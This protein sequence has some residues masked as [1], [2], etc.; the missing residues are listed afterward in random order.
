MTGGM[1][2]RVDRKTQQ[3]QPEL[4]TSWKVS[5][6]GRTIRFKLRESVV[7]SDGTPFSNEDVAYTMTQLMDPAVHSPTGD[8]FRSAPGAIKT[9]TSAKNTVEITFPAPV[10]GLEKLFDQV[11]IMSA[12][13]PNKEKAVLGPFMVGEYKPG[14]YVLLKRNSHYWK[15]DA[16]G[17]QLP[18]LDSVRLEL[19]QNRDAELLR[20]KKGDVQ[21]INGLDAETFDRLS[22]DAPQLVRDL[23]PSLDTEQFWFNQVAKAP[24]PD[25]KIRWFRSTN[26]RRAISSA[27]NRED[28]ARLVYGKHAQPAAGLLS[29]A[30]QFWFNNKL[31]PHTLDR[32]DALARL[33]QDGFKLDGKTLRDRDGHPVEFSIITNS[34]NKARERMATLIQQD[35]SEIGI[36]VTVVTLDFPSLLDRITQSFN[37]EACILGLQN[38][39]LD[40]NGQMNVWLS[41]SENHQWNPSQ[42][43]PETTWEADIDRLMRAQAAEID[44]KKR[45]QSFDKVQEIVWEQEPFLY[46]INKNALVGV[47]P[48]L[49]NVDAVAIRPQTFWNID[50]ITFNQDVKK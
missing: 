31:R 35:L 43:T 12:K 5:N 21:L 1:L 46:L 32:K 17:R 18:Y 14:A 33:A 4:A 39:D 11:A 25:Y 9:D 7:F 15:K 3:L 47:S 2:A 36:R 45:K 28:I 19:L 8:A 23:G 34:G 13:S 30:N 20:F 10:A 42:K 48:T 44:P 22:A 24:I 26:F 50:H 27:I 37:Y 49:R 38:T 41:T 40:P 16:A 29:P 6:G